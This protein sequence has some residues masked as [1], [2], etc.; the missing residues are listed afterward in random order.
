MNSMTSYKNSVLRRE[1]KTAPSHALKYQPYVEPPPAWL[2]KFLFVLDCW[3][4]GVILFICL[5]GYPPFSEHRTQVSLKDQITSGKHN[6]IPK[7]WAEVS[8]KALDLVKK[9]LVVDPK[10]CFTTEEALRHPWVQDEDMKRKFQDLLSE[11]NE[12]TALSQVLAQ[13]S[14]SQKRPRE[15]EAEGAETTKRLAVCAAVL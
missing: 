7:V 15:G 2:L 8:E 13:P 1:N 6:F 11:E 9:L 12:S 5:S 14:T 10:A 3:V 4:L